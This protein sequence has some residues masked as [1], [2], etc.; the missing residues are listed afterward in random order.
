M[1]AVRGAR[2]AGTQPK[3]PNAVAALWAAPVSQL[4][5]SLLLSYLTNNAYRD[6]FFF[7]SL[8][9]DYEGAIVFLTGIFGT[10]EHFSDTYSDMCKLHV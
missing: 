2:N 4:A 10:R 6:L 1:P 9:E 7:F 8:L 5:F 3:A